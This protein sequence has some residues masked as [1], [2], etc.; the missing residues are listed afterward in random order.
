MRNGFIEFKYRKDSRKTDRIN[1]EFKFIKN[2]EKVIVDHDYS[3]ND[4]VIKKY[5]ITDA[6]AAYTFE[7]IYTKYNIPD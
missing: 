6:P 4:W 7:F 3:N 1:G 2:S 5:D